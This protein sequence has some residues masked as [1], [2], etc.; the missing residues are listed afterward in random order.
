MARLADIVS[1]LLLCGAAACFAF[2]LS[3][4][5]E[6]RDLFALYWLLIGALTLRAATQLLRPRAG[7]R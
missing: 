1:V 6:H 2:G 7:S 5:G 3:A 4:L